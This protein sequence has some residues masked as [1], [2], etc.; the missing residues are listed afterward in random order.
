[1]KKSQLPFMT[2]KKPLKIMSLYLTFLS[3]LQAQIFKFCVFSQNR[4]EKKLEL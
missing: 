3:E 4:E 1:M 2:R